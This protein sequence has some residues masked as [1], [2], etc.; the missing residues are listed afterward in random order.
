MTVKMANGI[1]KTNALQSWSFCGENHVVVMKI[2]YLY[3]HF[4]LTLE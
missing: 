4:V 3:G 2:K 1:C